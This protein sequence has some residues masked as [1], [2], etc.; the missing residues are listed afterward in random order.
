[1]PNYCDYEMKIRSSDKNII[2][3]V[4]E[5]LKADYNYGEGKPAHK[6]L[7]RVF[8]ANA[9]EVHDNGDGTFT[10][11]VSGYCAWS[12][13]V[14]MCEGELT[15]YDLLKTDHPDIFMGTTLKELS[16]GCEIEAFSE[17]TGMAFSEHL[18]Y[19]DGECVTNDTQSIQEAGQDSEGRIIENPDYDK[20]DLVSVVLNPH[21]RNQ[22]EDYLWVIGD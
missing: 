15:Y 7:Q 1:M 21:R 14:C 16:K 2:K 5:C 10:Q 20:D 19:K 18:L 13:Y 8:E 17:E 11:F 12:L 4:L 9:D 22:T 6:H 3:N